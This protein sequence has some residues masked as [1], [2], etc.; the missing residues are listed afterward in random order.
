MSF[1]CFILRVV[2]YCFQNLHT[3]RKYFVCFLPLDFAIFIKNCGHIMIPD[4][5]PYLDGVD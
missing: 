5:P 2:L 1:L 4:T 3:Q